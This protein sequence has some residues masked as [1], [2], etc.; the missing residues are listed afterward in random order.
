VDYLSLARWIKSLSRQVKHAFDARWGVHSA[1]RTFYL[2]AVLGGGSLD[3][4]MR[5]ARHK[6]RTTAQKY[7]KDSQTLKKMIERSPPL[8]SMNSV[9]SFTSRLCDEG[10]KVA[11]R[12]H[13]S[14]SVRDDVRS[15]KEIAKLFVEN[16][17]GV[18]PTS[19]QYKS[20]GK[21]L[22]IAYERQFNHTTAADD[23]DE[24][25][26]E[27]FPINVRHTLMQ[28]FNQVLAEQRSLLQAA[29]MGAS[30]RTAL[31]RTHQVGDVAMHPS[32]VQ[33]QL[34][35]ITVEG[36]DDSFPRL[37]VKNADQKFVLVTNFHSILASHQ[38]ESNERATGLVASLLIEIINLHPDNT[39]RDTSKPHPNDPASG[40]VV[41]YFK[42][43][44]VAKHRLDRSMRNHLFKWI[45]PFAKCLFNCCNN[46]ISEWIR[47]HPNE[48][49][50]YRKKRDAV[51]VC[52]TCNH[53]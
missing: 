24:Y 27:N 19:S 7:Y 20:P 8:K 37:L 30:V 40:L 12:L 46:S 47:K 15:L 26:K 51:L 31:T 11:E 18:S 21:L 35:R 5:D 32:N 53:A 14:D 2:L 45:T 3:D 36:L 4:I 50:P 17:L 29:C 28:K 38:E 9:W 10:G 16:N 49:S 23:L 6:D 34:S 48:L 33:C 41:D 44:K 39:Q 43:F 25:L 22:E 42:M 13:R 52:Q 1:R